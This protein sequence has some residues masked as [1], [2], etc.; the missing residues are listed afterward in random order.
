MPAPPTKT[1]ALQIAPSRSYLY[2]PGTQSRWVFTYLEHWQQQGSRTRLVARC[3]VWAKAA[4]TLGPGRPRALQMP[5]AWCMTQLT[6][7]ILSLLLRR[8][9]D[10]GRGSKETWSPKSGLLATIPCQPRGLCYLQ[11][12]I[13]VAAERSHVLSKSFWPLELEVRPAQT[14][15]GMCT[16]EYTPW[17][18]N[19][20]PEKG[21]HKEDSMSTKSP[22]PGSM[23]VAGEESVPKGMFLEARGCDLQ[24]PPAMA[25]AALALTVLLHGSSS[26]SY[27]KAQRLHVLFWCMYV[28]MHVCMYV[29]MCCM[30]PL[31]RPVYKL[32]SYMWRLWGPCRI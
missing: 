25:R 9:G 12:P 28:C 6:K 1:L 31:I 14:L 13:S 22:L 7:V 17:K 16:Q 27:F 10:W 23:L 29:C 32:Y 4:S 3:P 8:C 11:L 19:T 26:L 2:T 24:H 15:R 21:T 18:T 5:C 30:A 20:T